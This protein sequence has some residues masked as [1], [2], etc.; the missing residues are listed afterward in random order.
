[1]KK[2]SLPKMAA[3]NIL[4]LGIYKLFWLSE[5]RQEMVSKFNVQI[6]KFRLVLL[7]EGFQVACLLLALAGLFLLLPYLNNKVS[8]APDNPSPSFQCQYDYAAGRQATDACKE[9]VDN[10]FGT[11]SPKQKYSNYMEYALI[12]TM[13]VILIGI[14]SALLL[15]RWIKHYAAAVALVTQ[16]RISQTR[17]TNYLTLLPTTGMLLVQS[18]YNE[19]SAPDF[20]G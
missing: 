6:P 2:R 17:A 3:L 16:N 14:L 8:T 11:T 12:G 7:I 10:Y 20:Q 15:I 19:S 13:A 1:M 4:T 18:A 9:A 5:T